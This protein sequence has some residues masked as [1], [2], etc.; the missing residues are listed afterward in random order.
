MGDRKVYDRWKDEQPA[1][2]GAQVGRKYEQVSL[3]E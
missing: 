2:I 1:G 3:W